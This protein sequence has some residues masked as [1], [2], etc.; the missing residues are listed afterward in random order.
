MSNKV[1][2]S[3]SLDGFIADKNGGIDWLSSVPMTDELVF[4]FNSLM[5]DIDALV[6]GRNTFE[7]VK[8]FGGQWPYN[9]KVFV[10]SNSMSVIPKEYEDKAE[11]IKGTASEIT[12]HLNGNGYENLYIDGGL[13]I[14]NFLKEDLI[15]DM[16]VTTIPIL[17]GGGKSLFGELS[18]QKIFK[19]I[20]TKIISGL[21][22]Q[23]HYSKK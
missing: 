8:G 21:V 4:E 13:T 11:L 5:E 12:E 15:D 6:M 20:S 22:V 2:I 19:I 14:Q 1:Y 18:R 7:V 16:V 9:K 10:V 3:T 17:L 23:N